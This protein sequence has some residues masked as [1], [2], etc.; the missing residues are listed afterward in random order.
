MKLAKRMDRLGTETAFVV[1]ARAK[2]LEAQGKDV[3]HLEI[4]EPDFD[5]PRNIID[6]AVDAL[7][8]GFTHYGPSAGLPDVRK[9][10]AEHISRDRGIQ[11][12]PDNVVV[13]PGGKPVMYYVMTAL[14]DE[15]D[16]VIYPNPG[17]P[18]YESQI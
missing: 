12:G 14:V 8:S 5:T 2:Q 7:R 6:K 17:F 11:V 3:V 1:L 18:I 13:T 10:I 4:G 15:G 16:E 9:V